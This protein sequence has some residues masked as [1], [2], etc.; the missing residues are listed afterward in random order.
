M[1][2]KQEK[3][4]KVSVVIPTYNEAKNLPR[5][6][7]ALRKLHAAEII[8]CDGHSTDGTIEIAKKLADKF[9]FEKHRGIAA[10]RN[11]GA[12]QADKD[13]EVLF[14]VDADT[15][16]PK[17]FFERIKQVF[18]HP[19]V[20]GAGCLVMPERPTALQEWFF[21]ILNYMIL[22]SMLT[23]RPSISGNAVAYRRS[24]FFKI[25]GF[26]ES[27]AAAEDQDLCVRISKLGRVAF[28]TDLT[29]QTSRRRLQRFGI[30]G[31]ILDWGPTTLRF[32]AG[33]KTLH[34]ELVR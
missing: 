21:K 23:G 13:S 32:M 24:A 29:V 28:F 4:I 6:I 17:E 14:F 16:P 30:I 3:E 20:V 34:Y 5:T 7:A 22:F 10:A 27:L 18:K 26:D 2:R 1:P 25:R 15:I 33:K 12:R 8:V 9:C 11:E 31:L 19:R